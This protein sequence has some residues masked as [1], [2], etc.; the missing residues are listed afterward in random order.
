MTKMVK[1]LDVMGMRTPTTVL[2]IA[3]KSAY[4]KRGDVL[5]VRGDCPN[6]EQDVEAWCKRL[7]KALLSVTHYKGEKVNIRIAF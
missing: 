6:L 2:K 1:I 5:D 7:G 4:M 3:L